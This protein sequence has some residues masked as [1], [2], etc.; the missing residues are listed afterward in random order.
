MLFPGGPL[1]FSGEEGWP[2]KG[3]APKVLQSGA[4]TEDVKWRSCGCPRPVRQG[5]RG[6]ENAYCPQH[7]RQVTGSPSGMDAKCSW[8]ATPLDPLFSHQ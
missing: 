2:F 5:C 1:S 7:Y 8:S 3:V 4:A 6:C